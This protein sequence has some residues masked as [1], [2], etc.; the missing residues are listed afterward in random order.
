MP[1]I[2]SAEH[3]GASRRRLP[4]RADRGRGRRRCRSSTRG[5][6]RSSAADYREF[7]LPHSRRIFDGSASACPTIHFGTGTSTDPRGLA[8]RRRRRDRRRLAHSRSTMRGTASARPCAS[9]ATW[10]PR[11]CSGPP[12]RML[13]QVDDILAARRR[14]S[15]PHL[16]SGPRHPAIDAGRARADAGAATSTRLGRLR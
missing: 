9:R 8:R 16:Q 2:D 5:S 6:A 10:I 7:A 12:T 11:C 4:G 14:P 3:S 13:Q 15:R 1:G